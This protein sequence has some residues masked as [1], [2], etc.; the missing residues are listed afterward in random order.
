MKKY[1]K[2]ELKRKRKEQLSEI[3]VGLTGWNGASYSNKKMISDILELQRND[4]KNL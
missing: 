2:T 1:T 4:I 3:L